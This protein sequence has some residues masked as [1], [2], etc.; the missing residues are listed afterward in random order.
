ML[1][2]ELFLYFTYVYSFHIM[3]KNNL[4]YTDKINRNNRN[5]TVQYN[6]LSIRI[7][8]KTFFYCMNEF[9]LKFQIEKNQYNTS[10]H[11]SE[12]AKD[13]ITSEQLY[14]WSAP[15][16]LIEQYQDYLETKNSSLANEIYINCS[17]PR[18]GLQCEYEFDIQSEDI[19]EPTTLTCYIH[20]QCDRELV[21]ICLHWSDICD[22]K[23]DCPNGGIDEKDCLELEINACQDDEYRCWNGICIPRA[24]QK[25]YT[26]ADECFDQFAETGKITTG[27]H[28]TLN[29]VVTIRR[30]SYHETVCHISD[31]WTRFCGQERDKLIVKNM[32]SVRDESVHEKCWSAFKDLL[33]KS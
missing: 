12:L 9:S 16:N 22:G 33:S 15:I 6:C 18:F 3:P 27:K 19:I 31:L 24:I 32:F 4:Y 17:W 29:D 28:F 23:V 21:P 5:H 13:N 10:L 26:Y 2:I 25:E 8:K 20:L 30:K 7:S 1:L 11:F 14:S